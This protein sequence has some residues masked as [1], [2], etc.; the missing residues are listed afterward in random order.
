ML[1]PLARDLSAALA[2]IL[3]ECET[4]Q[5][6]RYQLA[7]R[8]SQLHDAE[9][10][11]ADSRTALTAVGEVIISPGLAT[12]KLEAIARLVTD[13]LNSTPAP[14]PQQRATDGFGTDLVDPRVN[15]AI[16]WVSMPENHVD[17]TDA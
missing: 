4:A 9:I 14:A 2:S 15:P 17:P 8:T 7:E 1:T 10:R 16:G 13:A 11:Y 6:L 12:D 5:A 3:D